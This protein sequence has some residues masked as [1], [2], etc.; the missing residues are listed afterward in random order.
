MWK[1]TKWSCGSTKEM[2]KAKA[3]VLWTFKWEEVDKSE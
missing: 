3:P 2:E 1:V